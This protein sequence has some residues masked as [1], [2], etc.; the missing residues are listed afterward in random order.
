MVFQKT[1]VTWAWADQDP[2]FRVQI[3][4]HATFDMQYEKTS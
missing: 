1:E 4:N 2:P 3:I